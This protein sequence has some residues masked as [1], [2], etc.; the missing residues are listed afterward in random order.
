MYLRDKLKVSGYIEDSCQFR[1]QLNSL[2]S[3][4]YDLK[5]QTKK[6]GFKGGIKNCKNITVEASIGQEAF[7]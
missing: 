7:P 6:D 2:I 5:K 3:S 1:S 4:S